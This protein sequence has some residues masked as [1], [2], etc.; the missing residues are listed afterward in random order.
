[1]LSGNPTVEMNFVS[2]SLSKGQTGMSLAFL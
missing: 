2:V 1:M